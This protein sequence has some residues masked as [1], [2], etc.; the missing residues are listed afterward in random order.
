MKPLIVANWKCNPITKKEAGRIFNSIKT[1]T[2]NIKGVE[3]VVCPP[4]VY[5]PLALSSKGKFVLGAQ[6]CFWEEKGAFTGEVSA[7]ML[8]SMGIDYVIVGHSERRKYFKETDEEINGKIKKALS[9]G[10]KIILCVGE[11]GQ[12]RDSGKKTNVIKNQMARGL[13][14]IAKTEMK[15][16]SIAYEPVWAIGT[17]NNCSV[18]ETM[19]S[20]LFI[21]QT[22]SNI[23]GRGIADKTRI[24][25]GGSVKGDNS[26]PYIKE[27]LA[28][29]LLVGGASLKGDEFAKIAKS[30]L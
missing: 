26:G 24:L 1:G 11:T 16:I 17:G 18:E 3:I 2:K 12:E 14:R 7:L 20:V 19:T 9:A 22:L 5:L 8:K 15:N 4:F 21:R 30:A 25:Y 6:N 23:Y 29:G 10:L 13:E 28:N 27:A